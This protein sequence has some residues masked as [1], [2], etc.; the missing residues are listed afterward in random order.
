[1]FFCQKVKS[2]FNLYQDILS[3]TLTIHKTAGRE[4]TIL[5][6]SLPLPLAQED[7]DIVLQIC[8]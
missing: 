5:Y 4:G 6:S 8:M 7:S 1:M 3:Q 2:F